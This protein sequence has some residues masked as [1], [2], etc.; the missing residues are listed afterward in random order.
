[1]TSTM[2]DVG[3][4]RRE[5]NDGN[6]LDVLPSGRLPDEEVQL[7]QDAE[8]SNPGINQHQSDINQRNDAD[9]MSPDERS[10][11]WADLKT[12]TGYSSYDECMMEGYEEDKDPLGIEAFH[13]FASFRELY[14]YSSSESRFKAKSPTCAILDLA[15]G[16]DSQPRISLHCCSSSASVLLAALRQPPKGVAVQIVLWKTS[17]FN[18]RMVNAIGLGLGIHYRFFHILFAM[19]GRHSRVTRENDPYR[20]DR[21][22]LAPDSIA[23]GDA[24]VTIP[25]HYHSLYPEAT[26]VVLIASENFS[27]LNNKLHMYVDEHFG[28]SSLT[29]G[30]LSEPRDKIPPWLS[31]YCRIFLEA[32][33]DPIMGDSADLLFRPLI[34]MVC[35]NTFSI[36]EKCDSVRKDYNDFIIHLESSR[37]ATQ[38]EDLFKWRND[39]RRTIEKSEDTLDQLPRFLSSNRILSLQRRK[40]L[41]E[42][43]WIENEIKKVHLEAYR[44]EIEIRDYLQLQT[45]VVAIDESRKSIQLSNLQIEEGK[46][47]K[48]DT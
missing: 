23:I 20:L 14:E 21:R 43:P 26:P 40:K 24:V 12:R 2:P 47:G 25:R 3:S 46:R 41:S 18:E 44:L 4:S 28:L 48:F 8:P 36:R 35:F 39:L 45:G 1:M 19:S 37:K 33:R 10:R 13:L 30:S 34:P 15:T 11:L 22:Q 31:A 27:T 42:K 16:E 32:E 6:E 9:K 38:L 29:V 7:G 5:E 17:E